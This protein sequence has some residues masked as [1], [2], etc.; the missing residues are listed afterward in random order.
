MFMKQI[1]LKMLKFQ[2]KNNILIIKVI[3]NPL[4]ENVE[5]KGPKAKKIK[6]DL[7]KI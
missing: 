1:F 7:K 5:I 2:F 4:I 3:E 6:K